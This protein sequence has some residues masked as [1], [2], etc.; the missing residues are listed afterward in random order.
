M[1][2]LIEKINKVDINEQKVEIPC[3]ITKMSISQLE[4]EINII[5]QSD[6]RYLFNT[7]NLPQKISNESRTYFEK[8]L[9]IFLKKLEDI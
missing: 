4:H 1:E 6:Q 3:F 5:L 2:Y 8:E 9:Y 7:E